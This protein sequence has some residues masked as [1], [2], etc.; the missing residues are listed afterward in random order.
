MYYFIVNPNS[1]SGKG[2]KIWQTVEKQLQA[3][4][5][6]YRVY[7]TKRRGHASAL[8]KQLSG[9]HAPCTIVAVGGDGTA[10][11]VITGLVN[12]DKIRFGYIPSGSGNDLAAGL[13]LKT[14]PL[15]ALQTILHPRHIKQVS[16]GCTHTPEKTYRFIVSSGIG[17]DAAVCHEAIN[18]PMKKVLNRVG[19]GKLTYLGIALKQLLL[20]HSTPMTLVLDERRQ[21]EF[22]DVL[23][24]AVMNLR[25]E[26]GGFMFA[27][28]A[29]PTDDYLDICLI[30]N[31]PHARILRLLPTAFKGEHV[32][33]KGVHIYRCKKAV[34][35]AACP[36]AIHTDGEKAGFHALATM[37][38][39]P[40]RLRFIV[41]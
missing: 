2:M 39:E 10:N 12:L 3:E 1:S 30:E 38:L 20:L 37:E 27:P 28:E 8:A 29:D 32:H 23:F 22:D 41:S 19:L 7:F 14:H 31:M 9:Q 25:Y 5:C 17:Y 4:Q 21:F 15:D 11:E 35:R 24:A 26:G 16:I 40:E 13:G 34:I 33:Y 6:A 18:S 36:M